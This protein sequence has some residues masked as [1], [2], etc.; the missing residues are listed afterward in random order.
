MFPYYCF[1]NGWDASTGWPASVN[2]TVGCSRPASCPTVPDVR[3][4][5]CAL[6]PAQEV[7]NVLASDPRPLAAAATLPLQRPW[8]W[9]FA[10]R[11]KNVLPDVEAILGALL[12]REPGERRH[13]QPFQE[14]PGYA[15]AVRERLGAAALRE[16]SAAVP[17]TFVVVSDL[18]GD[19][20]RG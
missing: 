7:L 13:V 15:T 2:W 16:V 19:A 1:Y 3:V 8:S 6:A 20:A 11:G 4:F 12:E 17:T 5:G 14:L 18:S 10:E 9:L